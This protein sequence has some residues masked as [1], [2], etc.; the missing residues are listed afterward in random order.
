LQGM[1]IVFVTTARNKEEGLA[2]L[3]AL[4]MPFTKVEAKQ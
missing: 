1:E 4:G 3:E 2:L